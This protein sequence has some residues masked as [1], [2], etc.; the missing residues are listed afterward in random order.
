MFDLDRRV[1]E[2]R[3]HPFDVPGHEFAEPV[4][5]EVKPGVVGWGEEALQQVDVALDPPALGPADLSIELVVKVEPTEPDVGVEPRPH[6]DAPVDADLVAPDV[7][8]K[9]FAEGVTAFLPAA[10]QHGLQAVL[11]ELV[12]AVGEQFVERL[13]ETAQ[14]RLEG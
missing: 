13:F 2:L 3:E 1:E 9:G 5:L 10:S 14:Q 7:A 6:V 12:T 4:V 8:E 11:P